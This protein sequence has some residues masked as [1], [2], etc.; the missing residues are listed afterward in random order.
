[1]DRRTLIV[2]GLVTLGTPTLAQSQPAP[3]PGQAP[4]APAST[5]SPT[6]TY[7]RDEI[8]TGV[9]DFLG[10]T[11]EAAGAAVERLFARNGKPTGYIAGEE[12]SGAIV[13]G[14]R[15]GR[16]LLYMKDKPPMEVFWQ[17]PSAGWDFGANASRVFTLCYDLQVPET[18]LQRFPGVEGS[19]YFIGGL[20][21]NYQR[22]NGVT[23][24]PIRAGVGL[25]LGA[26]VGYLSY[27]R[28]RHVWP[29]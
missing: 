25:R 6:K 11:A 28:K 13:V 1:M 23:L 24:A 8:V 5:G 9:S 26:N 7:E 22:A 21:V 19:A 2:S 29:F 15:Y 20:G 27:S 16:G 4:G 10:V 14:A 18:I 17:G 12:G 3:Q